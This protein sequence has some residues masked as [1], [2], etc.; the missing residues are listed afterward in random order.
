MVRRARPSNDPLDLLP[1]A[2]TKLYSLW[3]SHTYPL[4]SVGKNASFHFTSKICRARATRISLGDDVSLR[5]YAWLN[6]ATDDYIGDPVI[7]LEENCHVGFG[8]IISARN[9]IHLERKVLVG[10]MVIIMDHNHSY[11]AIDIPVI[12]QGVSGNGRIHIGEGTWIGHGASIICPRGTLTIGKNCV[13]AANSMVTRSI[14][15]Y[16]VVFGNPAKI[17]KQFDPVNQT[18]I[19]GSTRNA[20]AHSEPALMHP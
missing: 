8:S 13:I 20:V 14:P 7:V 9:L 10:Q 18:W 17:I 1:R 11:E 2:I 3:L 4:A 5:E 6:V 15:D 12:D 16:S 19:I